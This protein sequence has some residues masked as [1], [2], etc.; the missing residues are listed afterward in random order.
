MNKMEVPMMSLVVVLL[1]T[2][3]ESVGPVSLG[4]P[5]EEE[6]SGASDSDDTS[7]VNNQQ[8]LPRS[9]INSSSAVREK[10]AHPET[11]KFTFLV[12][13]GR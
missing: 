13:L 5:E 8:M 11:S 12:H 4:L 10:P 7:L 9:L 6:W 1:V 2:N 3:F